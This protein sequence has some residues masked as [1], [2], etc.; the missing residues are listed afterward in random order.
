LRVNPQ[1]QKDESRPVITVGGGLGRLQ[2][3]EDRKRAVTVRRDGQRRRLC[4]QLRGPSGPSCSRLP[5]IRVRVRHGLR[6][7][8]AEGCLQYWGGGRA[9]CPAR[10]YTYSTT[11]TSRNLYPPW[12]NRPQKGPGAQ[13]PAPNGCPNEALGVH[14]PSCQKAAG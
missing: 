2:V 10:E 11:D 13:P 5:S 8:Q 7:R 6:S 4:G 9:W 1:L 3:D 12:A 14:E